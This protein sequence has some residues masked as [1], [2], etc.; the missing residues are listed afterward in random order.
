MLQTSGFRCVCDRNRAKV[1]CRL[2]FLPAPR[3]R[4][5]E[6]LRPCYSRSCRSTSRTGRTMRNALKAGAFGAASGMTE[7]GRKRCHRTYA[8]P[9]RMAAASRK[10]TTTYGV[11][12]PPL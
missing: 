3:R 4:S 2:V 7:H 9:S 5:S 8:F 10:N 1:G 12:R 11:K 6:S